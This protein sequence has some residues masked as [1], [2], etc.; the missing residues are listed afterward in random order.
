M[1]REEDDGQERG[2][3]PSSQP[4]TPSRT[5]GRD[6]REARRCRRR[7]RRSPTRAPDRA[8][9][10]G[11]AGSDE[12]ERHC[13][14]HERQ[15]DDRGEHRPVAQQARGDRLDDGEQCRERDHDRRNS[16]SAA[17][18]VAEL[19]L[20]RAV[21]RQRAP[22]PGAVETDPDGCVSVAPEGDLAPPSTRPGDPR[23]RLRPR[24]PARSRAR[25][26][27]LPPGGTSSPRAPAPARRRGLPRCARE[28]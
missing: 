25:R 14:R 13:E 17:S 1:A 20:E 16:G 21:F 18:S 11:P 2:P 28:G 5:T 8:A 7:R 27:R 9:G 4:G 23:S 15:Q 3:S 10:R 6:R 22:P 12:R 26:Q 19:V 24:C